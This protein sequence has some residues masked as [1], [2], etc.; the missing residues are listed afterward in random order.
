M[1]TCRMGA[2]TTA[3]KFDD[4][5]IRPRRIT[6]V[7]A[8]IETSVVSLLS[9]ISWET[10][11]GT[12]R[13]RPWGRITWRIDWPVAQAERERRLGLPAR[14]REDPCAHDLRDHRRVV[15]HERHERREHEARLVRLGQPARDVLLPCVAPR[16]RQRQ[17]HVEDQEDQRQVAEDVDPEARDE[18]EHRVARQPG[19]R[20]QQP[21]HQR[22]QH[23][24]DRDLEVDQEALE[25]VPGV[26]A[27]DQPLP[28][29]GV[30]QVAHR[31][32][33]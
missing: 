21:D 32:I 22:D 29:V 20:Q 23:R 30:E 8:M 27:G 26:V 7:I 25:D 12:I 9:V 4:V 6:S 13:R 17:R 31:R 18:R 3:K 28:V 2:W 33:A 24:D 19:Q 11:A 16:D 1:N 15:E 10:V 5:K 14:E